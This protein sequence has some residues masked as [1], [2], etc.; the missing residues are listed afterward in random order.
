MTASHFKLEKGYPIDAVT[1]IFEK[2]TW[3][4][5]CENNHS[6]VHL[7]D[8]DQGKFIIE[9]SS[10]LNENPNIEQFSFEK[11]DDLFEFYLKN[12]FKSD[13]EECH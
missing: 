2:N 9:T 3:V 4:L 8:T 1:S 5:R 11:D 13:E 7:Y 6:K 10:N 12:I